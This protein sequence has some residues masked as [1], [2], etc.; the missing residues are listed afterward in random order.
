MAIEERIKNS[1]SQQGKE[2]N[3]NT[4]IKF[5]RFVF[6]LVLALS[7]LG[8]SASAVLA[9][10]PSHYEF[11]GEVDGVIKD[12]CSF[13]VGI[14]AILSVKGT[15]FFDNSGVLIRSRWHVV[16]QDTFTANGEALVGFPFI[17]NLEF[18]YDSNGNVIQ[19]YGNGVIEKVPLPDGSLFI[20]AGQVDFGAHGF[21]MFILSADKGNPGNVAGFCAA[22]AP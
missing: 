1:G 20:S 7:T 3:M 8:V 15:D 17:S 9:D 13:D 6:A 10:K 2:V 12:L 22:L 5:I 18:I 21:P 11:T 4:R 14:Q 16:E 19:Q